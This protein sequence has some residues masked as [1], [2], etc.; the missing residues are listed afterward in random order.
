M[1]YI[2][3]SAFIRLLLLIG[4]A[5]HPFKSVSQEKMSGCYWMYLNSIQTIHPYP[6]T[7]MN[8]MTITFQKSY[9][10]VMVG[11]LR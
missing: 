3:R 7:G 4:I 11:Y 5:G 1:Q 9:F 6:I 2:K 8:R 10:F